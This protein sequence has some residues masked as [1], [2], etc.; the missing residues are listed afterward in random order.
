MD[1][2]TGNR[3]DRPQRACLAGQGFPA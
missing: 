2:A 1:V 3:P